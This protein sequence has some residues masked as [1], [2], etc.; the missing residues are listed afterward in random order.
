M[1]MFDKHLGGIIKWTIGMISVSKERI[2]KNISK[3]VKR[4]SKTGQN[5]S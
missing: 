5:V 3:N 1:R 4:M 2:N